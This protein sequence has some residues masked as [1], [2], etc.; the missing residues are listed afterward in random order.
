M[1]DY[2]RMVLGRHLNRS[3]T[4]LRLQNFWNKTWRIASLSWHST[5]L[6][7]VCWTLLYSLLL[8]CISLWCHFLLVDVETRWTE[9]YFPFTHP[10]FE[11][12]VKYQDKWLEL[13]GCGLVEQQILHNGRYTVGIK[14]RWNHKTIYLNSSA[15]YN[16]TF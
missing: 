6:V 14:Q 13:L 2:L 4:Q 11:L 15:T 3:I 16:S 7:M 10:S 8:C 12:E 1:S 9:T 5:Y